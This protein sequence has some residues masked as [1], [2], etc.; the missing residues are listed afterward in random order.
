MSLRAA[1][2]ERQ[3]LS[4]AVA[5]VAIVAVVGYIAYQMLSTSPQRLA[6]EA[7]FTTDDGST[8][9]TAPAS[10]RPPFDHNGEQAVRAHVFTCDGEEFVGYLERYSPEAMEAFR[11]LDE[12]IAQ[13]EPGD[14]PPA[15]LGA[16]QAFSR[17]GLQVKKPGD[18]NWVQA[19]SPEGAAVKNVKCPSGDGEPTPVYP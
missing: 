14:R 17:N 16:A 13:V 4:V 5:I 9:F 8:H 7:F 2:N 11:K 10:N 6:G 18:D 15:S 1:I 12:E 19:N 3:G